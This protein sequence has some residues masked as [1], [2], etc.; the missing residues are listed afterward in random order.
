M[1]RIYN[2]N[3]CF[4]TIQGRLYKQTS[5][6]GI[7]TTASTSTRLVPAGLT[8][9]GANVFA[10][11]T[12]Q[13]SV[14]FPIGTSVRLIGTPIYDGTYSVVTASITSGLVTIGWTSSIIATASIS[15]STLRFAV[16]DKIVL[17]S[18]AGLTSGMTVLGTGVTASTTISSID[19][20]SN[21]ITLSLE[22]TGLISA[23]QYFYI[24]KN[25]SI[26]TNTPVDCLNVY[27]RKVVSSGLTGDPTQ[28]TILQMQKSFEE[29]LGQSANSEEVRI[30]E[31]PTQQIRLV[32]I[33]EIKTTWE[34]DNK[35]LAASLNQGF[36]PGKTVDWIRTGFK[37]LIMDQ[38][39]TQKAYFSGA[40]KQCTYLLKWVNA[41]TTYSQWAVMIGPNENEPGFTKKEGIMVD[42]GEDTVKI[43]LGKSA[44]TTFLTKYNR[45]IFGSRAWEI[46]SINDID[47]EF[48]VKISLAENFIDT[49]KDDV[50]NS[51]ANNEEA[52][53]GVFQSLVENDLT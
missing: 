9:D 36:V 7:E 16:E 45:I 42:P 11:F 18:A 24:G 8:G 52:N 23:G 6:S 47:S 4:D 38:A 49:S 46:I 13:N 19:F 3:N 27:K 41:S 5:P 51:V 30:V 48:I 25:K 32:L 29:V 26:D 2:F 12:G 17:S 33:N 14:P 31:D 1:Q 43:F 10:T 40:M 22:N 39:L 44:A 21:L 15:S 53:V 35:S 37:Y 28:D 34:D 20:L 50:A